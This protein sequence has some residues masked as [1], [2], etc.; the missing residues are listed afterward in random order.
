M[1]S[2]DGSGVGAALVA[3]VASRVKEDRI[4]KLSSRPVSPSQLEANLLKSTESSNIV[5]NHLMP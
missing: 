3:A 5:S 1:L 4:R 2:E